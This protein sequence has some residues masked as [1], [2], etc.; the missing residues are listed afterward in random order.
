[1]AGDG[2]VML[3]HGNA[4]QQLSTGSRS[5]PGRN[6]LRRIEGSLIV[7]GYSCA[8]DCNWEFTQYEEYQFI[9]NSQNNLIVS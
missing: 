6:N 5:V 4:R 1:M 7:G 3:L 9:R 2:E 8:N